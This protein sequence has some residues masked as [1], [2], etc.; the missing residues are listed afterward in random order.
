MRCLIHRYSIHHV[1]YVLRYL[2]VCIV[3]RCLLIILALLGLVCFR[4]P[5]SLLLD[6]P[7]SP[8]MNTAFKL[9]EPKTEESFRYL[10]R[11]G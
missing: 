8:T 1:K 11:V 9:Q 4:S 3:C 7:S 5:I 2:F 6:S 10:L